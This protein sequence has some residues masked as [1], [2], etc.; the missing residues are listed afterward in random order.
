ML[1]NLKKRIGLQ[2]R[3]RNTDSS[4]TRCLITEPFGLCLD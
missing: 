4:S 2:D 3:E 1:S